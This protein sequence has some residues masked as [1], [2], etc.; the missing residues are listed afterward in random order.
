MIKKAAL[1]ARIVLGLIFV[2]FGLNA[3]LNFLPMPPMEGVSAQFMG[4]LAG[5]GYLYAIKMFEITG[6]ILLLSGF[7]V[8]LG[9]V[10]VAPVI[11][12]ILFFHV[13]MAPSGLPMAVVLVLLESF[14]IYSYR[15]NFLPLFEKK[16]A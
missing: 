7:F 14:L 13:F 3:F 1:I 12:N 8:P 2:V 4:A 9:L 5:S 6:G 16:P 10:L 11:T 15:A